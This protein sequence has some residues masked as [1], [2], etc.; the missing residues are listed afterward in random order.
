[1]SALTVH[2]QVKSSN[3]FTSLLCD[4]SNY[5]SAVCN[6]KIRVLKCRTDLTPS[7]DQQQANKL[8]RP[9]N[10]VEE[11]WLSY[12]S[13]V[14]ANGKADDARHGDV[15]NSKIPVRTHKQRKVMPNGT[16][17]PQRDRTASKQRHYKDASFLHRNT[18]VPEPSQLF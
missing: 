7:I 1:L 16:K 2:N 13:T 11:S 9:F 15:C 8:Q 6:N 3:V 18:N 4:G 12:W 5:E 17:N 14:V 10:K